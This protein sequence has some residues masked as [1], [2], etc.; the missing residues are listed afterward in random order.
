MMRHMLIALMIALGIILVTGAAVAR[1]PD[2]RTPAEESVCDVLSG[3]PFGLCNAYCEATD[4]GDGVN[5]ANEQA[6]QSLRNNWTKHTGLEEFPCECVEP[7][8]FI[9]GEG[10]VC[11]NPDLVVHILAFRPLGCP[12]GQGSCEYEVDIQVQ[13]LTSFDAV[14]PFDVLVELG[15]IGLSAS[16]EF[17]AGLAG[18][19][20]EEVLG[21]PLGP[22]DN[23]F[24][25]NCEVDATVDPD[26]VILECEELNNTDHLLILG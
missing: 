4:C 8:G 18:G 13:N 3:A 26:N 7:L 22:G 20:M 1:T 23:C 14:D 5:N 21:I 9:P 17:P 16:V 19:G 2:G 25:P 11:V 15:E 6:C 12:T 24:N 10:C